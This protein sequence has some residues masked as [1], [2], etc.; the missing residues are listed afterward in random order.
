MYKP[1]MVFVPR[2]PKPTVSGTALNY[3][4]DGAVAT[5]EYGFSSRRFRHRK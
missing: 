2:M 4:S 1:A 5:R 3:L